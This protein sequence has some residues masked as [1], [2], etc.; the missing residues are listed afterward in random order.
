MHIPTFIASETVVEVL[1]RLI[2]SSNIYSD[3]FLMKLVES[4]KGILSPLLSP[5]L[6]SCGDGV[7]VS[8]IILSPSLPSL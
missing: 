8:V 2:L 5:S 1:L 3:D 7:S 6:L 4:K